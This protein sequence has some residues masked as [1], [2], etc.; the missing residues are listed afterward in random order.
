MGR[1]SN[2]ETDAKEAH[3][4]AMLTVLSLSLANA[5]AGP[6]HALSEEYQAILDLDNGIP[7]N[8][9]VIDTVPMK[10]IFLGI[11]QNNQGPL[12]IVAALLLAAQVNNRLGGGGGPPTAGTR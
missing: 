12:A 1:K 5:L 3:V 7:M 9:D 6:A 11:I 10:D 4:K 2:G 8:S